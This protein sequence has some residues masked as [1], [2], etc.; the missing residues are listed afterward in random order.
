[1]FQPI[2]FVPAKSAL[3]VIHV[4]YEIAA[5]RFSRDGKGVHVVYDVSLA[6]RSC[7]LTSIFRTNKLTSFSG[8]ELN[9]DSVIRSLILL[10][11][12]RPAFRWPRSDPEGCVYF[13]VRLLH[14]KVSSMRV[15]I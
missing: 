1:M 10:G 11:V 3:L 15:E 13:M 2:V 6:F 5:K 14:T 12:K 8:V 4:F 7:L 9:H